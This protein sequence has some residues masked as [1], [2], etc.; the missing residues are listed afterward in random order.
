[1]PALWYDV[2]LFHHETG[3]TVYVRD[4]AWPRPQ[5]DAWCAFTVRKGRIVLHV[6][7]IGWGLVRSGF[8][9]KSE[10]SC[11]GAF[12]LSHA[13]HP[14]LLHCSLHRMLSA[15]FR[16]LEEKLLSLTHVWT[17]FLD[18]ERAIAAVGSMLPRFKLHAALSFGQPR[19]ENTG[20]NA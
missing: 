17:R 16:L 15:A 7:N 14:G 5:L 4:E 13:L 2:T 18:Q 9:R 12:E 11:L 8:G 1:M 20:L 6:S 3:F 10:R 19:C